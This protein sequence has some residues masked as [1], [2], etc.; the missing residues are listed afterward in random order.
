[1][2]LYTDFCLDYVALV[3]AVLW[4][5]SE[6]TAQ[7]LQKSSID[8]GWDVCVQETEGATPPLL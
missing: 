6:H 1:M 2:R 5:W 7:K 4:S 3:E 8:C